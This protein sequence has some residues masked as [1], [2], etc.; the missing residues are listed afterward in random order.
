M[1]TFKDK[2][3]LLAGASSE[4]G[5]ATASVLSQQ[6]ATLILTGRNEQTLSEL[7]E[8]L[9]MGN[10]QTIQA[11]IVHEADRKNITNKISLIDGFVFSVGAHSLLPAQF[12]TKKDISENLTPGFEALVL[13]VAGLLKEKKFSREGA[14]MVFVSS[15]LANYARVGCSM[16][17]AT[18]AAMEAYARTLA[19]ELAP[20]QIRVNMVAPGFI[21]G[22]M[23]D[24]SS[25]IAG[26]DSIKMIEQLHPLGFG[27]P[28]DV[29]K[30]I[31][32]LLSDDAKWITGTTLKMGVL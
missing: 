2:T 3:I 12:I 19:L 10:H 18:K 6:G 22:S 25:E 1:T 21:R 20:K 16:Y 14:A 30:S 32:F 5:R 24:K 7:N 13:L 9:H 23:L 29:A 4:I 11:D 17:S 26:S 27:Y 8:S 15:V 28:S 31:S